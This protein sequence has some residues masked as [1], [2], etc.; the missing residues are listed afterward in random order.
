LAAAGGLRGLHAGCFGMSL[1]GRPKGEF[2][3]AQ[4]EGRLMSLPGRPK[5]ESLSA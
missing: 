1:P 3:S 5:G 2:L 4:R